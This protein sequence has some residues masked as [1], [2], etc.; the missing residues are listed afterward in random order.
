MHP[1]YTVSVL[2]ILLREHAENASGNFVVQGGFI[3]LANDV[4]T[5]F[6]RITRLRKNEMGK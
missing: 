1:L 3:V 2:G 5:E 6:L 4:N